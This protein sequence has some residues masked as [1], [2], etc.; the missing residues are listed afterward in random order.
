MGCL[1]SYHSSCGQGSQSPFPLWNKSKNVTFLEKI[2]VCSKVFLLL[3]I[4]SS[5][6]SVEKSGMQPWIFYWWETC[7]GQ[8]CSFSF[9]FWMGPKVNNAEN[10]TP[11]FYLKAI[12]SKRPS[13]I[14]TRTNILRI[15]S[16]MRAVVCHI[17]ITSCNISVKLPNLCIA[18][19]TP[20]SVSTTCCISMP[21]YNYRYLWRKWQKTLRSFPSYNHHMVMI[22]FSAILIRY[23]KFLCRS[24]IATRD[25]GGAN[26]FFPHKCGMASHED[27][28]SLR[29]SS[30]WDNLPAGIF[31]VLFK[32]IQIEAEI[33]LPLEV[34]GW[35]R[36]ALN[37]F[38]LTSCLLKPNRVIGALNF[39]MR[40]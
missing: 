7:H 20:T 16:E 34:W 35:I 28:Y 36:I 23:Q 10:L 31:D 25:T 39:H 17:F 26:C 14:W 32:F 19:C 27:S 15:S 8:Y 38:E 30:L 5:S 24:N 3:G 21:H 9:V 40:Y 22:L 6:K 2:I 11:K 29:G 18:T 37:T 33:S 13:K 12:L 1:I 4:E